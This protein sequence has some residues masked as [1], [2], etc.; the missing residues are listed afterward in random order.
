MFECSPQILGHD[1]VLEVGLTIEVLGLHVADALVLR[2][3]HDN[4]V[5]REKFVLICLDKV[6]DLNV[7]PADL[8]P[9]SSTLVEL[10]AQGIVF[11]CIFLVAAVVFVGVLAH[12]SEDDQ[13]QGWQHRGLSIRNRDHLD[14]LHY[15][16][17]G[18]VDIGCLRELLEQVYWQKCD[19]AV[20]A[21][22]HYVILGFLAH[23]LEL[24][25][26]Q[27][28]DARLLGFAEAKDFF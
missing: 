20:L 13:E 3:P 22:D 8:L 26:L 14:G 5:C 15:C 19:P 11:N 16:D 10:G 18:K 9:L 17:H 23:F 12:G 24:S 7:A 25:L 21:A 27:R 28:N 2:A 6:A 1:L 4:H